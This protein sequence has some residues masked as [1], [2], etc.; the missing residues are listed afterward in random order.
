LVD[1]VINLEKGMDVGTHIQDKNYFTNIDQAFEGER[2]MTK[3][4]HQL[5]KF[6]LEGIPPAPRGTPQIEATFDIDANGILN[7]SAMDKASG[8]SGEIT[9][10]DD[11]GRLSKEEIDKL[12]ANAEKSKDEDDK[13][14]IDQAAER[15]VNMI[16]AKLRQEGDEDE[17][18]LIEANKIH[19]KDFF[20]EQNWTIKEMTGFKWQT[21]YYGL[22]VLGKMTNNRLFNT[23]AVWYY[24]ANSV[25]I[26][27]WGKYQ[28]WIGSNIFCDA[29][30]FEIRK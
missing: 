21:D 13:I 9:I 1:P 7:V 2:G 20:K 24:P 5:G 29:D 25:Q 3:D 8:E 27:H 10:T 23:K 4:N 19:I 18:D 26:G 11:K 28:A 15:C 17:A 30:K 16:E 12:V 14:N 6:N 22:Q